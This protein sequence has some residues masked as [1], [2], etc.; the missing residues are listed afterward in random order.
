ME[1]DETIG[2]VS[3]LYRAVTGRDIPPSDTPYAPIPAEKDPVR[4]V[5]EQMDRL[6]GLLDRGARM[7]FATPWVPPIAIYDSVSEVIVTVD[8]PGT[9]RE[10]IDVH[11]ESGMLVVSGRRTPSPA[12]G[13]ALRHAEVPFGA[14]R[15]VV[16]L[17]PA[18]RTTDMTARLENGVL[19]VR[20]PR[21]GEGGVRHVAVS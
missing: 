16:P 5:N 19:E 14:F 11:V 13:D 2:Q 10:G 9:T 8:L 21:D 15:R 17:I 18:L 6:L 4:H 3:S 12:N 7:A 20:I 1:L